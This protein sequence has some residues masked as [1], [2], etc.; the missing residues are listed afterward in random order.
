MKIIDMVRWA[1]ARAR[2]PSTQSGFGVVTL[3]LDGL[4][5]H[6]MTLPGALVA[7]ALGFSSIFTKENSGSTPP[8]N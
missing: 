2:E 1:V 3:V 7:A 6:G 5:N 4:L 8:A